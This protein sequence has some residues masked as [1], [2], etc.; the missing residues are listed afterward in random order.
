[1]GSV[2]KIRTSKREK[3]AAAGKDGVHFMKETLYTAGEIARIAGVSLRTIRFYD[4]K[5]LL[6]PV[7]HSEAGY[8]YYNQKSVEILQRIL[9]LKYLGFSL[10]KI[11]QIL[12]EQD[13]ELELSEQ[14][15]LLQQKKNQLE[16]LISAIEMME[17][18][19][20][21]DK[22]N[23]L[24]RLL[25][26]LTEEEKVKE[27]YRTSSNLEKRIRIHDYSTNPQKWMDWVYERLEL[28]EN[29]RVLE[30]G[31]GTGLLW[32]ENI[33][34][35]PRGLQLTLTDRSEGMLEKTRENLAGYGD[36]LEERGIR[37][38][39]RLEDADCPVLE[40]D[41]YDCVIANHMLYHVK[42]REI[43]L[44][45]VAKSLKAEGTFFCS[46]IGNEH[47][48][49]L[50]ELVKAFDPRIEMPY[51]SMTAGFRLENAALQLQPF[52]SRIERMD[53]ENDL[54]VDDV[55]AIYEYAH[56]YPGNAACILEQREEEF[57]RALAER[58]EREG[59]LFIRK[60]TGMF[61]CRNV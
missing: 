7:S 10:Q 39:C 55:E 31:C 2:K 23:F 38:I 8:R 22:W 19:R 36:L 46:T 59:A 35:L 25:N 52:F 37:I 1:M 24:L 42:E 54:I 16:E 61:R 28:K 14:K 27:Q 17:Q 57:R 48:R 11:Q 4:S 60:A 43:C 26:L 47:M 34:R 44:G 12:R 30:L 9:M 58:M 21:E 20:E 50:H 29:D 32:Q 33:H 3:G 41:F 18:S 49:E 56:S 5:G 51:T 40:K 45:A 15:A 53:Q 13:M 6:K